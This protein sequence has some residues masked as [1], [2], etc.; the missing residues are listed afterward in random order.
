MAELEVLCHFYS[1]DLSGDDDV[2][3]EYRNI[4]ALLNAWEFDENEAVPRDIE[5]LL[6]FLGIPK[7]SLHC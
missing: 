6:I 3:R 2:K 7:I 4:H 1:E 5:D